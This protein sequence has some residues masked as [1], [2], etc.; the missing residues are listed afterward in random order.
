MEDGVKDVR[1]FVYD[2]DM[3]NSGVDPELPM[4]GWRMTGATLVG[5]TKTYDTTFGDPDLPA[6][7]SNE[8]SRLTLSIDLVRTDLSGFSS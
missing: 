2:P 7:G 4:P 8:Y 3:A 6:G 5:S 1:R